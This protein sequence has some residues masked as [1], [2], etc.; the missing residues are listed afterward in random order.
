MLNDFFLIRR[1][2]VAEG[3]T[4][5]MLFAKLSVATERDITER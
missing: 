5:A 3:I 4:A 2:P 1:R